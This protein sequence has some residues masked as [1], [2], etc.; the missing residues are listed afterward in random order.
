MNE[1]VTLK[2]KMDKMQENL[3]AEPASVFDL[4]VPYLCI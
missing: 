4:L 2:M 1:N 3:S